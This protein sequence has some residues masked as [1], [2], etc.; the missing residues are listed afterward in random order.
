MLRGSGL[1]L[2][3]YGGPSHR[4]ISTSDKPKNKPR[5]KFGRDKRSRGTVR[6]PQLSGRPDS[7]WLIHADWLTHAP[8]MRKPK[9]WT[10]YLS[11]TNVRGQSLVLAFGQ[12]APRRNLGRG[13]SSPDPRT[14]VSPGRAVIQD[15][16]PVDDGSVPNWAVRARSSPTSR[17][18][19]CHRISPSRPRIP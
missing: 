5:T 4:L 19:D 6:Q 3:G 13:R 16:D 1:S 10:T 12:R 18:P 11:G 2:P 14:S 15:V 9:S 7:A 17:L 8:G